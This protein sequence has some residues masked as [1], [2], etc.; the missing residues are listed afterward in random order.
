MTRRDRSPGTIDALVLDGSS[1]QSLV[2]TRTLGREGLRVTTGESSDL[3][4]PRFGVPTFASRW[5]EREHLL[6][7]YHDDPT[8]YAQQ[9]L[10]I[11]GQGS[12]RVLIPCMDGSIAALRPWR[13]SFEQQG[14]AVA[15]ASEAALDTANDKQST[16]AVA[17]EHGIPRPRTVALNHL[18]DA[19]SALAD[20]EFP[21]V[22]KPTQSWVSNTGLATRVISRTVINRSEALDFLQELNDAGSSSAIIQQ[23]ATG[24]R[25]A[26]SLFY[27]QERVWA[28]FA[29]VAHRTTPVLG[30]VSVVRESIPMPLDLLSASETLVRALSLEGYSE[31]EFRRD[32]KGRPLLMEINAR[33]SGSLEMAIRSGVPFPALLWQWAMREPLS[34]IQG[35]RTGVRMR[36]LKG[37]VKW[38]REN[39]QSRGRRPECVPPR[40]AMAEFAKDF[41]H[42]QTYDYMDRNDLGPAVA[43]LAGNVGL[44]RRRLTVDRQLTPVGRLRPTRSE[45]STSVPSTDVV[46]IGAGPN[47]LSVAAH[48]RHAGVEHRV[49][50]QT[51][52][53]WRSNMPAGMIL[54]SE[55][56]ASDLS[57]PS[58]GYLARDYCAQAEEVYHERVIPLSR[59]QFVDYGSWFAGQLVPDLEETEIDFLSRAS[60]GGFLLRT[61]HGE[62]LRAARVVVATGIIPFAYVPPELTSLPSDLVSHTSQHTN[63]ATFRGKEVIVVGG[64]SSALE[65]AALLLEQGATVKVV[66]RG[67]SVFWPPPNPLNPSRRQQLR[68]PIARLCE[69][70]HCWAYDQL[71]D[72]FRLLPSKSRVEKAFGF[73][74]PQGAWW[75]RERV[76]G[77]VPMLFGHEVLGAE[78]VGDRVQIQLSGP[79]GVITESADHIIAGTGFRFDLNRLGYLTPSI[80]ADLK[81]VGGAPVLDR[82]LESNVPGLFVTGA[83][84]APSMGPLMRFVAG[85]HF[86]GPRL[87]HRLGGKRRRSARP[88]GNAAWQS[89]PVH[90]G[91]RIAPAE[92]R[93]EAKN[94][95]PNELI[96]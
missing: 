4:D 54:K 5:S 1:R 47:G 93:G 2:A 95:E 61:A 58:A 36:Y 32:A 29:Q 85:T 25:E 42:R 16:L 94:A 30:G 59:E 28:S 91:E 17:A 79:E 84:A 21:A 41:L 76:E 81:L 56:Y 83:L 6:P 70:W 96:A 86:V 52:G 71:P 89:V 34:P 48:L 8:A 13:Q 69:G 27:A 40:E 49:F 62:E 26:V 82:N 46:V 44:A 20:V 38:L 22:I 67:D 92:P 35:Y 53:A 51:M 37:D 39:I 74:G 45:R 57:A 12:T 3:C 64:G 50:G 10:D 55:P 72:L 80:R 88:N 65:T 15:L 14:V 11:V 75:L 68:K 31:I 90:Q 63:L 7:S 24:A 66:M 23:M 19:L 78:P 9:V 43:A 77:K 33:L 18:G 60:S 87:A 73:L